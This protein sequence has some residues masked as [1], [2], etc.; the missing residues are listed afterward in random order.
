MIQAGLIAISEPQLDDEA[1][2][3]YRAEKRD[4]E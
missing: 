1:E 3:I 2:D 4:P